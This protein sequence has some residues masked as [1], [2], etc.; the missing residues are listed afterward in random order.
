M[1]PRILARLATA[2]VATAL[3][4]FSVLQLDAASTGVGISRGQIG[5]IPVTTFQPPRKDPASRHPVIVVAHGFA[6]SQQLMLPFALT[7]ARNGYVVLTFD[8]PGHGRNSTPMAGGVTDFA[9]GTR[10]LLEALG[11]VAQAA[12]RWPGGDGRVALL[13]HSMAS[14]IV[15]RRAMLDDAVQGAVVLSA[16]SPVVTGTSPRNLLV[17]D[18]AWEPAMLHAEGL[19]IVGLALGGAEPVE[20]RT[21]GDFAAGTAR[22]FVLADGVEHISILYS[23]EAQRE[24]LDWFER[25]LGPIPDRPS[26]RY[27]D[28]RGRWLALLYLGLVALAWPL[29]ALLPRVVAAPLADHASAAGVSAAPD[30]AGPAPLGWRGLWP[31]AVLPA[32]LTPLLLWQVPGGFLPI[33]LG[34]YL[35]L[36]FALY[37]LLTAAGIWMAR[38][39][40]SPFTGVRPMALAFAALAASVYGVFAIGLPLDRYVTS[41]APAGI[42][43][44]LLVAVFCGTL[45]YFLADEWLV[46]GASRARGAYAFTK[47]MFLLSLAFAIAL[48]PQ[49]LFFLAIVVPAILIAF[50]IYGLFSR[51]LFRSIG[52]PWAA[53]IANAVA[54]AWLVAVTFPVV[55]P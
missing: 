5:S 52:H 23:S 46:R 28:A 22:R 39:R 27:V 53:A 18:G 2:L 14:D 54:F 4:V 51:W 36:H 19:R 47:L 11:E 21:Y 6:G 16:Y 44:G 30:A 55:S 15:I 37:G 38:Q 29:A 45:A 49:R 34:D 43:A 50:V 32:I 9:A 25:S 42:R 1:P 31:V 3:I 33:L 35:T 7:L 13:G 48:N 41:F 24:T 17:V 8:L 40:G 26:Q 20:A 10:A 12:R